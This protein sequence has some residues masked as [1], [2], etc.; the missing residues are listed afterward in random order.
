MGSKTRRVFLINAKRRNVFVER[1]RRASLVT[2][3]ELAAAP[4]RS[5]SALIRFRDAAAA[6]AVLV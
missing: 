1:G 5:T 6:A 2:L 4:A 3:D